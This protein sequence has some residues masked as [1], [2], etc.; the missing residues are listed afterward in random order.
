MIELRTGSAPRGPFISE[1]NMTD[2][3]A[4]G[5]LAERAARLEGAL[6]RALVSYH[7]LNMAKEEVDAVEGQVREFMAA[8]PVVFGSPAALLVYEEGKAHWMDLAQTMRSKR[9]EAGDRY[10]VCLTKL[11]EVLPLGVAVHVSGYK[12]WINEGPCGLNMYV[13]LY[14]K[15]GAK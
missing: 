4:G 15:G 14:K 5:S 11:R 13:E 10:D 8:A 3:P 12:V 9:G 7:D 2:K 1:D 6:N